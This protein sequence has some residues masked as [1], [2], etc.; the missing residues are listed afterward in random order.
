MRDLYYLCHRLPYPP[1]RGCR[2]RSFHLLAALARRYRVR[3]LTFADVDQRPADWAPLRDV[4][5]SVD[6]VPLPAP[7][8]Y[9]RTALHSWR[10]RPLTISY[11][12][13]SR[14]HRRVR[15][16]ARERPP[17]IVVA[18]SSAMA[19]YALAVPGVPRVMDMVDVDSA[20]WAQY[21]GRA[22]WPMRA[23]Y[24]LE[25]RRMRAL[26]SA[27]ASRFDRVVLATES[28]RA[29]LLAHAPGA[30]AATV[31]NG[32]EI[33]PEGAAVGGDPCPTLL[34]AGQMDYL[35]N[36]DAVAILAREVLPLLRRRFP[37]AQL[38]VVGRCPTSTVRALGALPGVT[39]SGAVPDVRPYYERAWLFAAP[40][41]I[42]QGVQTKVME[43]MAAGM[44]VV[45]SSVVARGLLDGGVVPGR[46]LL[47]AD[48]AGAVA[49]AV[50]RLLENPGER[51]AL[52][53][54][55]R[56]RMKE[57]FSWQRSGEEL[58][59]VLERA[60]GNA[61]GAVPVANRDKRRARA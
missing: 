29:L 12:H 25:T 46:D 47:V 6:V 45:T 55:G 1:D 9:L 7:R 4:C 3:L 11:F 60:R 35:P 33:G 2:T 17:S 57:A 56:A 19:P 23:V 27:I 58:I 52:A 54:Q 31:R 15:E 40:L 8:A 38:L 5:A 37:A 50:A 48:G 30:P 53:A 14:L 10:A 21:A 28:E 24:A 42:A 36:V 26:E 16:L 61:A 44:P 20:K 41:Q 59:E 39:V 22:P 43:A 34:F 51:A 18:F 49:V 32:V 13:S